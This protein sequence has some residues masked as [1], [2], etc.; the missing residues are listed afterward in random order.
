MAELILFGVSV[1]LLIGLVGRWHLE[2]R[3]H[4]RRLSALGLRVHVNG[5]RG[6]STVTRIV[7][8]VL[9]EAGVVT[10]AKTT[11]SAA[12]VIDARSTDRPI[13]RR[14]AAT[15]L[16]QLTVV[17]EHLPDETQAFVVE[18]MALRPAYQAISE[19]MIVRSNIGIITNVREDHQ[20]IMGETL[21]E[22]ARSLLNTCPR[23]G[24]LIT[25][26]QDPTILRVMQEE[27]QRRGSSLMI[28]DPDGVTDEDISRFSYLAFKENVAIGLS[29][30]YLLGIPRHRAIDGMV[31]A[32]PDPGALR[33]ME[34][35]IGGKEVTWANLLAVNDRESAV[36]AVDLV[37]HHRRS[38]STT[39]CLLNNRGDRARRAMQF[40]DVATRDLKFDR[41][42]T[43]GAYER[44]VTARLIQN[45]FP[46]DRIIDLGEE[47]RPTLGDILERA[48]T[49]MPTAHVLLIGMVNIH[50]EHAELLLDFL[51]CD[52]RREPPRGADSPDES[53]H[54]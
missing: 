33:I 38:D 24:V 52:R 25:A 34:L 22:I 35:H 32:A 44:A 48:V 45:G 5:I 29:V 18:C 12:A 17:S 1:V 20:E 10:V 14:G 53:Y 7:A 9:R 54:A 15:I 51:E 50:T 8:G 36:L 11:G 2:T 23:D 43:L 28:A 30:A 39:V 16:E 46:R 31:K 21:P 13:A 26:E 4:N 19:A 6:K 37:M 47:R 41:I 42:V 3:A 49:S 40:A 27:A